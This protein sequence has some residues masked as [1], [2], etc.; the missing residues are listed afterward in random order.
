MINQLSQIKKYVEMDHFN[1]LLKHFPMLM[2]RKVEIA[3]LLIL[4]RPRDL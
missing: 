4:M 3:F 2:T 1:A